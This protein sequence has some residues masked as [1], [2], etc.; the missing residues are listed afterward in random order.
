MRFD[1][2]HLTDLHC[3]IKDQDWMWPNVRDCLIDD[4]AYLHEQSGP[5]DLV[6]FTGDLT[7]QGL[8]KEF[9]AVDEILS[10]LERW[11]ADRQDGRPPVLLAVPGNHDLARPGKDDEGLNYLKGW[12]NNAG[13]QDTFWT[14]EDSAIRKTVAG[15][16][17]EYSAWW[18][19]QIERQRDRP[20]LVTLDAGLLP[21][22]F[23]ATLEN[24]Q[25]CRLGVLGLNTA[26]LQ[27]AEGDYRGKLALHT[28]QFR[29]AC[30]GDG[31][32]WAQS[33]NACVLMTHHPPDWLDG[34]SL[35]HLEG[36]ITCKGRF[37]VHL[38]GHM[39]EARR[40]QSS[41]DGNRP[42]YL[43]QARSLFGLETYGNEQERLHGYCAGRMTLGPEKGEVV[44][45]PRSGAKSGHEWSLEKDVGQGLPKGSDATAPYVFEPAQPCVSGA[46]LGREPEEAPPVAELSHDQLAE[47]VQAV[48]VQTAERTPRES[49]RAAE[50][51]GMSGMH[52]PGAYVSYAWRT[53]DGPGMVDRLQE[54]CESR[55]IDLRRDRNQI[56]Y[57]ASIKAFMQELGAG[58]AVV[59]LV[60]EEY[61]KS[62][63]CMYELL[64][65]EKN[66]QFRE[67]I[68]PIV[69]PSASG[70]DFFD[71]MQRLEIIGYWE[72][73]G[74]KLEQKIQ[75]LA[76]KD[77]LSTAY[78]ELDLCR[79]VRR[80]FDYLTGILS[81]MYSPSPATHLETEFGDLI[82]RVSRNLG[83]SVPQSS[84]SDRQ[85]V[86]H[87]NQ[88]KWQWPRSNGDSPTSGCSEGIDTEIGKP[89]VSALRRVLA[90]KLGKPSDAA[91][92]KTLCGQDAE[93]ALLAFRGAAHECRR[94]MTE[95]AWAGDLQTAARRILGFL[96][97]RLVR[98]A[99]PEDPLALEISVGS[100]EG[101]EV[102]WVHWLGGPE[103]PQFEVVGDR[104]V[105]R[106]NVLRSVGLPEGGWECVEAYV[107]DAKIA[108]W[109][110]LIP[111]MPPPAQFG[112][113]QDEDLSKALRWKR[114]PIGDFHYATLDRSKINEPLNDPVVLDT[115]RR[116]VGLP[117]LFIDAT[118]EALFAIP[119]R[120]LQILINGCVGTIEGPH[121]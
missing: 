2:L 98:A 29:A 16:F 37:A 4:L 3:G 12:H 69:L 91:L 32:K 111:Y 67:R 117:I 21:G 79:D 36:E 120:D 77:H 48:K 58:G 88:T 99:R 49:K 78:Q 46:S 119:E 26:F 85:P 108:L 71:V 5:W 9:D 105:G 103:P 30:G 47:A 1:W 38:C 82:D 75:D 86:A 51:T 52:L 106:N 89:S 102:L 80:L 8:R 23:A 56:R 40:V 35:Q 74:R 17:T 83:L 61:L 81:D 60:S 72:E 33:H 112:L 7:Q 15:A 14:R 97:A 59:V 42:K 45:W 93:S 20:G 31:P 34:A 90:E 101:A 18:K 87:S 27:L 39:H 57:G 11:I 24:D 62:P 107:H 96:L 41:A 110:E 64:E 84:S 94:T 13:L 70:F 114:I 109:K 118:D 76:Q 28:H 68:Q 73:R 66:Q 53:P 95:A 10:E 22:D 113:E 92:G 19:R 63:N 6:L 50:G 104:L 54:A 100:E 43:V 116:H 115:L 65:I 55:G 44:L 121:P 25:G